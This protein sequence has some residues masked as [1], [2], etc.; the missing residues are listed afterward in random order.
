MTRHGIRSAICC[1]LYGDW[2]SRV[3]KEQTLKYVDNISNSQKYI[4]PAFNQLYSYTRMRLGLYLVEY[5]M[6]YRNFFPSNLVW[7]RKSGDRIDIKA[8]P[9]RQDAPFF[10]RICEHFEAQDVPGKNSRHLV[11]SESNITEVCATGIFTKQL[12]NIAWLPSSY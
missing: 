11:M 4:K 3:W 9:F 5:K 2:Y 10:T 7:N 1:S 8:A 6:V 12:Q